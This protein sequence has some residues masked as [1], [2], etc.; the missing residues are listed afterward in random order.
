VFA[1]LYVE[2]IAVLGLLLLFAY[3]RDHVA[4]ERVRHALWTL[5]LIA[6]S[7]I[8]LGFTVAASGAVAHPYGGSD[9][10]SPTTTYV[11]SGSGA[12][13]VWG[14]GGVLLGL[15]LVLLAATRGNLPAWLRWLTLGAGVLG[16]ASPAFFPSLALLVWAIVIGIWLLATGGQAEAEHH[17]VDRRLRRRPGPIA[18]ASARD[19][20]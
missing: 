13:I 6:A 19:R 20:R 11:I 10:V 5:G 3:L 8:L 17:D 15:A 16:L 4:A 9:V 12:T 2:I 14:P 1:S 18:G 7:L